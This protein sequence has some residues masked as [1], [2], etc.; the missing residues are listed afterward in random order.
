MAAHGSLRKRLNGTN[1]LWAWN[2]RIIVATWHTY[3]NQQSMVM[4]QQMPVGFPWYSDTRQGSPPQ[5]CSTSFRHLNNMVK[6][7]DK[8]FPLLTDDNPRTPAKKS[9]RRNFYL[10]LWPTQVSFLKRKWRWNWSLQQ[11]TVH[12]HRRQE[13]GPATPSSV[14]MSY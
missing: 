2:Q 10:Y 3:K 4:K 5:R 6:A 7:K 11:T 1:H 8:R 14:N 12:T 9:R 13:T